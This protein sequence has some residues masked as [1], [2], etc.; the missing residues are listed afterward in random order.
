MRYENIKIT[1]TFIAK[2][3]T[4]MIFSAF[5]LLVAANAINAAS[6]QDPYKD[7]RFLVEIDGI[8][9]TSFS[10]VEGLN[11]SVEVTEYRESTYTPEVQLTPGIIRYGPVI[12]RCGI[13]QNMELYN[14]FKLVTQGKIDD[15]RRNVGIIIMDD[16]GNPVIRYELT[17]AWPSGYSVGKLDSVNGGFLIEELVIQ[18]ERITRV[19]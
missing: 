1:K 8:V 15:A 17:E 5:F 6:K 11:A 18:C 14:W 19:A 4:I 3:T 2:A 10:E 12:L 7:Y 9:Q 16:E 13:S